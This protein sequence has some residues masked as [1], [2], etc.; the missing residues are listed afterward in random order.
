MNKIE[1]TIE[2]AREVGVAHISTCDAP[3]WS[4]EEHDG[5]LMLVRNQPEDVEVTYKVNHGVHDWNLIRIGEKKIKEVRGQ[6]NMTYTLDLNFE[7]LKTQKECLMR[8]AE[9]SEN[10]SDQN[11]LDG[12]I[13]VIEELQDQAVD[14]HGLPEKEVFHLADEW[15]R[16]YA[17]INLNEICDPQEVEEYEL[18]YSMT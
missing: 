7:L 3:N 16:A 5:M 14:Q 11:N 4:R 2:L 10:G 1:Q 8:L 6:K 13:N 17:G 18:Y 9:I 12:I 15:S